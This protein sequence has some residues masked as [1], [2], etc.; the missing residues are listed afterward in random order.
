M[1]LLRFE[2]DASEAVSKRFWSLLL[3][4]SLSS[5]L[6]LVSQQPAI[7][8]DAAPTPVSDRVLQSH[9]YEIRETG[10]DLS[11]STQ[12]VTYA[13]NGL[14]VGL[15]ADKGGDSPL[16][17]GTDL[18]YSITL[19]N[20]RDR[21]ERPLGNLDV[22]GLVGSGSRVR[23]LDFQYFPALQDRRGDYARVLLSMASSNASTGCRHITVTE[24][25]VDLSGAGRNSLGR[26][27]Y[28]LPCLRAV[29]PPDGDTVGPVL[30]QSG[31]RL[32]L[33]PQRT[34]QKKDRPE[35][36]LTV[37]DFAVLASEVE[38]VPT[39]LRRLLGGVLRVPLGGAATIWA[40]GLRNPQGLTWATLDNE[41]GLLATSHGPRGGDGLFVLSK[42]AD[43]GWPRQSYGTVYDRQ[44]TPISARPEIEGALPTASLPVFGWVP[45]IGPSAVTQVVGGAFGAWWGKSR[46]RPTA[47]LLVAGM[48]AQGIYRLRWQAGAVRYVEEIPTPGQRIRSMT[49][50]PT[51]QLV[52]GTDN[53]LLLVLEPQRAW[54]SGLGT[55]Q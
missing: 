5:A 25:S 20:L 21:S 33:A 7:A 26:T 48:G 18:L 16:L 53:G 23:T 50:A 40:S 22:T 44:P 30:H 11:S 39:R 41:A 14:I 4:F 17:G 36:F 19:F 38:R 24:V 13:K 27:W 15:S 47:D 10:Y 28:R 32:A 37:G 9:F 45:S 3:A 34:W 35:I 54:N 46:T 49:F 31:G 43:Y 8:A 55:F 6:G 51:G 52:A 29:N 2:G 12:W 42:S 1:N